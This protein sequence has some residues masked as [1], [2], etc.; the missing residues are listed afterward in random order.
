VKNLFVGGVTALALIAAGCGDDDDSDGDLAAYCAMSDDLDAQASFP[1]DE[2]LDDLA[3]VAP[4]EI[5]D[6]VETFIDAIKD[7]DDPNDQQQVEA[8]FN[9]PEVVEAVENVERFENENCAETGGQSDDVEDEG[10]GSADD[11]VDDET[12]D[13]D[14]SDADDTTT[15]TMVEEMTTTTAG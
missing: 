8:L 2:Q 13:A 1:T 3:D 14:D 10:D 11:G 6:D 15:T 12:D 4:S 5:K 7:L 9:D